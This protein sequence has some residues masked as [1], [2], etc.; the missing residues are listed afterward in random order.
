MA[1]PKAA[2]GNSRSP[3]SKTF[4]QVPTHSEAL[5]VGPAEK[6]PE[7]ITVSIHALRPPT[8][9]PEDHKCVAHPPIAQPM[10]S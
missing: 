10:A 9:T 8:V 2:Q 1:P 4:E 5:L 6:G 7:N 3:A